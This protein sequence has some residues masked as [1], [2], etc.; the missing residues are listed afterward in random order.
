MDMVFSIA[1]LVVVIA[2]VWG[3]SHCVRTSDRR[4]EQLE[5]QR[6]RDYLWFTTRG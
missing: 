3:V 2:I 6:E 1:S 4:V 5:E